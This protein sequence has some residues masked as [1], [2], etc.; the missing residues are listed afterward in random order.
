MDDLLK[1]ALIV[2]P[3][4]YL[5]LYAGIELALFNDSAELMSAGGVFGAFTGNV[6]F[7]YFGIDKLLPEAQSFSTLIQFFLLMVV[8]VG[9]A[10]PIFYF[11]K[12][13]QPTKLETE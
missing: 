8:L 6:I 9:A 1:I 3:A 5:L 13:N 11:L 12:L 4:G 10:V 2:G 7:L